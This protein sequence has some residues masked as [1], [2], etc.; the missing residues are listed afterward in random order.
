[1]THDDLQAARL[2]SWPCSVP[3]CLP[4]DFPPLFSFFLFLLLVS[5]NLKYGHHL[6]LIYLL[7]ICFHL[8]VRMPT[9]VYVRSHPVECGRGQERGLDPVQLGT[10]DPEP[11]SVGPE[12]RTLVFSKSSPCS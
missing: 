7:M 1:M 10:G 11:S 8:H 2:L 6:A 4:V 12:T 3:S 5:S 9:S